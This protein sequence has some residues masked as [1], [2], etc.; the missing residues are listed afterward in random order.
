MKVTERDKVLLVLLGVILIVALAVVMPGVGVMACRTSLSD[1]ETK[2]QDLQTQLDEKVD[3]LH[4][5]GVTSSLDNP[6]R[7]ASIL[8][9]K[10]F[11]QKKEASHL[12]GS[13]MPYAKSY[14]VDESW[15]YGLKYRYGVM[16]DD[17]EKIVDYSPIEDVT[18]SGGEDIEETFLIGDN[19]YSLPSHKREISFSISQTANCTYDVE[20]TMGDYSSAELGPVLLFMHNIASKGS[21]LI[22][23]LKVGEGN[24]VSFT[25]V[26][27]PEYKDED[28][29]VRGIAQYAQEVAEYLAAQE[30]ENVD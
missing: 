23:E 12:A 27:P 29:N 11:E 20:M 4:S 17:E 15:L 30:N 8:K 10:A 26:M 7:A 18:T 9:D 13:V 3:I 1:Y 19:T 22:T 25:I 21:M 24:S 5:M 6:T 28:G 16:S 2:T 14:A